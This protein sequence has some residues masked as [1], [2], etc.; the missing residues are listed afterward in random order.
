MQISLV[1]FCDDWNRLDNQQNP[2]QTSNIILVCFSWYCGFIVNNIREGFIRKK[3]KKLWIFTT[4]G[5]V[6][7]KYWH[8]HNFFIFFLVCSNSSI[9]AIKIFFEGGR[10]T[11]WPKYFENLDNFQLNIEFFLTI[12]G[13]QGRIFPNMHIIFFGSCSKKKKIGVFTT[14]RGGGSGPKLWKF[15][16]FFFFE[17]ILPLD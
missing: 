8:F 3:K 6:I 16:T 15:T 13:F 5:G 11:P 9:S 12:L 14:F 17:W 7:P 1:G 2:K 4:G 10:G